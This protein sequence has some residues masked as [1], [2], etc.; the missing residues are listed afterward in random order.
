MDP[1]APEPLLGLGYEWRE[2]PPFQGV[3]FV[4]RQAYRPF[5][6]LRF[7]VNHRPAI[8]SASS[9]CLNTLSS[10][11]LEGGYFLYT[12]TNRTG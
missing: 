8:G 1:Q 3:R 4:R 5:L 6:I 7:V 2:G 11:S 9:V 12:H 10:C